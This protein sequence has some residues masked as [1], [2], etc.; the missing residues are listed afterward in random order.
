MSGTNARVVVEQVPWVLSGRST[1]GLRGQAARL[2]REA[3][4]DLTLN[5]AEVGLSLVSSRLA[6][7]NR[8]VVLG[9]DRAELLAGVRA[10]AEGTDAPNVIT[11]TAR[12]T[13]EVVFV[14]PGQGAQWAGMAV[15]LLESAPVFGAQIREC[16]RALAPYVDWSLVDVLRGVDSAPPL[17]RVDVVQPVLFAM[18]VSLARLWRSFGVAP[19]AVVGHSQGEI[20]AACVAGALSLA[21]AAR[22][23][24]LRSKALTAIRGR[25][26]MV[27]VRAPRDQ[28][29]QML[30]TWPGRLSV[31]AVNGPAT[32]TV[33]GDPAAM[34]EFEAALS[35]ARMLRWGI[36]GVDFAAHSAQVADIRDEV[37]RIASDISPRA[38]E[39]AFYST[40]SGALADTTAL[41]ARYW[42]RNL[43]QTVRFDDAARALLAD[44]YATFLECGAQPVLTVGLQDTVEETGGDAVILATLRQEEGGMARFLAALA[45]AHVHGV[46]VDWPAVF[47]V[48]S[49]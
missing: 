10:L 45:E 21:D 4:S 5:V 33:S 13:G 32:T 20:A 37:V 42:Y 7:E 3:D 17:D 6:F 43:R 35:S 27:T 18:M 29:R 46:A 38:S 39:V 22:V 24:A 9:R 47:D 15:E 30:S 25:G 26:R 34:A 49:G 11:G 28:V 14:F 48:L 23:V 41:D 19:A 16:E 2:L 1:A 40:V 44:G 8:A 12:A 31:A 36:P